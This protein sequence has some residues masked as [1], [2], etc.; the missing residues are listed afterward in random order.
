MSV[1]VAVFASGGG[2]NFQSLLDFQSDDS[3][4]RISLLIGDRPGVPVPG[5][6]VGLVDPLLL[7]TDF[8]EHLGPAIVRIQR[9]CRAAHYIA[10]WSVPRGLFGGRL[11]LDHDQPLGGRLG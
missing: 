1:S 5:L 8:G 4:G 2:S 3:P 7:A 9:Q 10:P 6:K 11:F